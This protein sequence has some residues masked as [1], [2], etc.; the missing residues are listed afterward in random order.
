MSAT[1]TFEDLFRPM[2]FVQRTILCLFQ[3][4]KYMGYTSAGL[5]INFLLNQERPRKV[6][7]RF[8]NAFYH[9]SETARSLTSGDKGF[10]TLSAIFA[11]AGFWSP[12]PF[13][14]REHTDN[15]LNSWCEYLPSK[16]DSSYLTNFTSRWRNVVGLIR[17]RPEVEVRPFH[18]SDASRV[19]LL[20]ERLEVAR[21]GSTAASRRR[22]SVLQALT[23]NVQ[24]YLLVCLTVG[25]ITTSSVT[26]KCFSTVQY[27]TR[28]D[29][30]LRNFS[31]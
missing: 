24:R 3:V 18:R 5:D 17:W 6:C 8:W 29:C 2:E 27:S 23:T 21:V 28:N 26:G 14:I 4:R 16:L 7:L 20:P 15:E 22:S 12:S 31:S 30:R 1:K 11:E 9:R 10:I 19:Q 13:S 25:R